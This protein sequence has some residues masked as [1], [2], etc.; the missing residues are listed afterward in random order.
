MSELAFWST[1]S[2]NTWY[3]LVF[4]STQVIVQFFSIGLKRTCTMN[5]TVGNWQKKVVHTASEERKAREKE[6]DRLRKKWCIQGESSGRQVGWPFC[7]LHCYTSSPAPSAYMLHMVTTDISLHILLRKVY[8]A[9]AHIPSYT[10]A[11]APRLLDVLYLGCGLVY[12]CEM[13]S[14]GWNP[15][16]SC[17]LS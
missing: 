4:S 9:H 6:S 10:P 12:T 16:F 5:Q 8:A 15:S 2:T 14:L 1:W 3:F 13:C 17:L 11:V 7:H